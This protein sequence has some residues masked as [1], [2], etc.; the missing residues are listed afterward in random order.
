VDAKN[1]VLGRLTNQIARLLMG[2]HKPTY[3][4]SVDCGDYVV[5][6][7]AGDVA[8][9][10]NKRKAK[11]YRWHT[12]WM[13]GLKTL[14]AQQMFERDP[15]RVVSLA[16]K[17]MLP[18]NPIRE[19]RLGRLRIFPGEAHVHEA[20]VAQSLAYAGA[21]L[22]AV[23]PQSVH[24]REKVVGGNLVKDASSELSASE[25]EALKGTFVELVHD[26]AFAKEYDDWRAEKVAHAQKVQDSVDLEI[27]TAIQELD[28]KEAA[29]QQ[30]PKA[31]K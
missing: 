26:P 3:T 4:P 19:T 27:L 17:G 18:K 16:V 14:T 6:K 21:H 9:T 22:A 15:R 29:K 11:L 24:P 20:Q 10:G 8:L 30:P 1:Q 28:A 2:K 31:L 5:V 13:G 12:G 23:A 7:N 25:M